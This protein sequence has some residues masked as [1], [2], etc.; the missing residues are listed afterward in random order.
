[1]RHARE[2]SSRTRP[3]GCVR[4]HIRHTTF[5]LAALALLPLG[6][7]SPSH[8][9]DVPGL[10]VTRY[11]SPVQGPARLDFA[12]DGTLFCGRDD[13]GGSGTAL[14]IIRVDPITRASA[15]YGA[16]TIPD[17]DV[18]L[19]D[20]AGVVSGVAGSVLVGGVVSGSTGRISAIRPDGTVV[21]LWQST[22]ISNPAE[23]KFD[24]TGRLV[25]AEAS[26]RKVMVSTGAAPTTLYTISGT[27]APG[28]L[29]LDASDRIYTSCSDGRIRVHA[30]DGTLLDDSLT[31]F[32]GLASIEFGEGGVFGTDLYALERASNTLYRVDSTGAVSVF[33][34][35]FNVGIGDIAFG[36][37]GD[38]YV[39]LNV[40][41][42]VLRISEASATGVPAGAALPIL[43][44]R[45][46]PNPFVSEVTIECAVSRG[47]EAGAMGAEPR[48]GIYDTAGRLVRR[49]ARDGGARVASD[50]S[51]AIRYRWD[52]RDESGRAT[53]AGVFFYRADVGGKAAGSG[54]LITLSR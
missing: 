35:G 16:A 37:Y 28:Y 27:A 49:L 33:G 36:R 25:F 24:S 9:Q 31:S 15:E 7:T 43:L 26:E 4:H 50:A 19:F 20:S 12:P 23:M 10:T 21:T 3:P 45:A 40:P 39:G 32:N 11:A 2:S 34:T 52:G 41:D 47:G 13:A 30:P 6:V 48:V 17:P 5:I 38:L 54:K 44:S 51:G 8:A 1:M 53:G 29:A 46:Y 42:G 18:A 22:S 14:K